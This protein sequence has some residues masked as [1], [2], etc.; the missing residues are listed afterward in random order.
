[1]ISWSSTCYD[2]EPKLGGTGYLAILPRKGL[3]CSIIPGWL[4]LQQNAEELQRW[5]I[6]DGTPNA[7][8][9]HK[10][11]ILMPLVIKSSVMLTMVFE[12]S[13]YST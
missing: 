6:K 13:C 7:V 11:K 2:A 8:E 1:M 12:T 4:L 9:V 10:N 5:S 3:Y